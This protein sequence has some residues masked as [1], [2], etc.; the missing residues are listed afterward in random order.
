MCC[1]I[2]DNFGANYCKDMAPELIE[3]FKTLMLV[4]LLHLGNVC[5]FP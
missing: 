1:F 5:T 2:K 4:W 3:M